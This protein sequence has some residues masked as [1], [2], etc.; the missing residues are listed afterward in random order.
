MVDKAGKDVEPTKELLDS[1]FGSGG[2]VP[3]QKKLPQ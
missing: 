3:E 2:D 1:L